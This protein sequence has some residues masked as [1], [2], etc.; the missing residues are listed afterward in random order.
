MDATEF[1]ALPSQDKW[2]HLGQQNRAAWYCKNCG[3]RT[4]KPRRAD[5]FPRA[6]ICCG[7]CDF[8]LTYRTGGGQLD[9]FNWTMG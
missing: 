5:P 7:N 2:D 6:E 4:D 9:P 3:E 8:T 1:N